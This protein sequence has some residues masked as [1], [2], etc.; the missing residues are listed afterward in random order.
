[1]GQKANPIVLRLG[2]NKNWQS[3]WYSENQ[4]SVYL[5]QDFNIREFLYKKFSNI[6]ISKILIERAGGEIKITI[7]AS[8]PGMIVG[9]KGEDLQ[10]LKT[11]LESRFRTKITITVKEVRKADTDAKLVAQNIAYQIEKR[12]AFRRVIKKAMQN[13]MRFNIGGC[14]IM[15]GGRLNGAE[16]SRS[17][18]IREGRIPLHTL[19]ADIDY[20][21]HEAKTIY[22]LIGIKV[23]IYKIPQEFGRSKKNLS[24]RE[25][26]S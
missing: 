8:R 4:Y 23:W 20:A 25:T 2:I 7:F 24:S 10:K 14:K 11:S 19:K 16:I 26:L 3:N 22:G 21:A 13:A 15:V 6:G 5:L 1:M 12:V 18:W 17:E 9:R